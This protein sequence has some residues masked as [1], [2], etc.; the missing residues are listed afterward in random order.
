MVHDHIDPS[1]ESIT[2]LFQTDCRKHLSPAHETDRAMT[3]FFLDFFNPI[4]R[5]D[6]IG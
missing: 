1:L 5:T 2:G 6:T 4:E 3:V